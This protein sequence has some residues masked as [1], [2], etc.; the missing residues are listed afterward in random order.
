MNAI[1]SRLKQ[2]SFLSS[3]LPLCPAFRGL[4]DALWPRQMKQLVRKRS[5]SVGQNN[6]YFYIPSEK[7]GKLKDNINQSISEALEKGT[8]EM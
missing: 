1:A 6:I 2:A 3:N 8:L 4:F 7:K 5:H